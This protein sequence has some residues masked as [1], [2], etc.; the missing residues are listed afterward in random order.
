MIVS[1]KKDILCLKNNG[2]FVPPNNDSYPIQLL[3]MAKAVK[4]AT[5]KATKK[6]PT[7]PTKKKVE[8]LPKKISPE[9]SQRVSDAILKNPLT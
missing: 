1:I 5:K 8:S 7:K 2:I 3:T 6:K 4:K 9:E